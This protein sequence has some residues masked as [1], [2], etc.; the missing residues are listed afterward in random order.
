MAIVDIKK[1]RRPLTLGEFV[2]YGKMIN[3]IYQDDE[4][5][6]AKAIGR[7]IDNVCRAEKR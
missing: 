7:Y 5:E 2:N 3:W 6:Q 4:E 1:K